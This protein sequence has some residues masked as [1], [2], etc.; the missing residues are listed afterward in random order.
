MYLGTSAYM[1]TK[2]AQDSSHFI[3]HSLTSEATTTD[4]C[5]RCQKPVD[6]RRAALSR[7]DNET[8]VCEPCGLFEALEAMNGSLKS[9]A[10]WPVGH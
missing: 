9:Q 1:T 6:P 5:P 4:L 10:D 3:A 7:T 8:Q 2:R